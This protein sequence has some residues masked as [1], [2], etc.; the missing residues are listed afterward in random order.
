[1][2]AELTESEITVHKDIARCITDYACISDR[3]NVPDRVV[4]R[5]LDRYKTTLHQAKMDRADFNLL[6]IARQ[7]SVYKPINMAITRRSFTKE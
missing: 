1:L 3:R 2:Q 6:Q 5:A 7:V 4:K